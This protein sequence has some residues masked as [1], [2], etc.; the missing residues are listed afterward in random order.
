MK[1]LCL[2]FLLFADL[3]LEFSTIKKSYVVKW[4]KNTRGAIQKKD[5]AVVEKSRFLLFPQEL[6]PRRSN[7]TSQIIRKYFLSSTDFFKSIVVKRLIPFDQSSSI[8]WTFQPLNL[9]V[10][11]LVLAKE[12]FVF[13]LWKKYFLDRLRIVFA[14]FRK[15]HFFLPPQNASVSHHPRSCFVWCSWLSRTH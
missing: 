9:A 8:S 4:R 13:I 6:P 10:E 3:T 11:I 15:E 7:D 12:K 2:L 14:G 5:K 1:C